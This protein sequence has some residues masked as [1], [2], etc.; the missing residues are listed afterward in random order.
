MLPPFNDLRVSPVRSASPTLQLLQLAECGLPDLPLGQMPELLYLN[1]SG[2]TLSTLPLHDLS[3][4]CHLEKLDVG[5]MPSLFEALDMEEACQCQTFMRWAKLRE[6]D[7]G[8][9]SKIICKNE[10]N[11]AG[12]A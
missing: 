3:R 11:S 4:M 10:T 8:R 12:K 6:L 7:L 9:G 2:N 1:V 5:N